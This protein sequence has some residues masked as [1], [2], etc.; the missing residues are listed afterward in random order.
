MTNHSEKSTSPLE[1]GLDVVTKAIGRRSFCFLSTVSAEGRPHA[2]GVIYA[3]VGTTLY[4]NTSRTSR[5]ARNI[6]AN[7]YVGIVVPVRRLPVGGP[8]SSVQFQARADILAM[9]DPHIVQLHRAGRLKAITG[10]GELEE[11]DGCFVR[12]SPIGRIHTYA[13]GMPLLRVIRDPLHAA[14]V[15]KA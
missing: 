5:K 10:H 7:P 13:L 15:V 8:P 3:P 11:P 6:A 9:D 4:V 1:V 12:I 2:A 14:G